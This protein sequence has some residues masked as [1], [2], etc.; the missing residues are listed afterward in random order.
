MK[1]VYVCMAT[2]FLVASLIAFADNVEV[3]EIKDNKG[4]VYQATELE[5]G[6]KFFHDRDLYDYEYPERF[7]RINTS[8]HFSGLSRRTGL[9]PNV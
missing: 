4:G 2:L 9:S 5:E 1:L 8:F 7:S 6:G 3:T